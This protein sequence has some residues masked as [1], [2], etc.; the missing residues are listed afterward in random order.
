MARVAVVKPD[1]LGDFILSLPA[2]RALC[3]YFDEI[4][5]FIAPEVEFLRQHFLPEVSSI[6]LRLR[7]LSKTGGGLDADGLIEALRSYE[8]VVFLRDDHVMRFVAEQLPGMVITVDSSL[9]MHETEIQRT[10]LLPVLPPYS[11]SARFPYT[12]TAWPRSLT[13]AGLCISAGFFTNKWPS[14]RWHALARGFRDS[15]VSEL[16]LI[17]GP[18]ELD[19]LRAL[20]RLADV[21]RSRIIVGSHAVAEFFSQIEACDAVFGTDSGTLHMVSCVRPVFGLFTSSPW[22][23]FAPFGRAN[24]LITADVVCSPCVQFSRHII[25]GCL[26]KE[27]GS[28]LWPDLVIGATRLH[29]DE[30]GIRA[31]EHLKLVQ[32]ASH[33]ARAEAAATAVAA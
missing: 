24:R 17:G 9:R 1:H 23:R 11:R 5:L 27:C 33:L 4:D 20:A 6:P 25:N 19:E 32:G 30:P 18:N 12:A 28:L 7:H 8:L 29:F 10:A 22:W 3:E 15:G 2:I 13:S 14:T 21:G 26:A 31:L 16:Y